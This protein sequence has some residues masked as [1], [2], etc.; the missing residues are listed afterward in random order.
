LTSP[1]AFGLHS[2]EPFPTYA[3]VYRGLDKIAIRDLAYCF[4]GHF[5][6]ENRIGARI[7]RLSAAIRHW[8]A[9]YS[10]S[11][12]LSLEAGDDLL[13][14][15]SRPVA[16]QFVTVLKG[17]WRTL[18]ARCERA[19]PKDA[20]LECLVR[21]LPTAEAAQEQ[22]DQFLATLLGDRLILEESGN[23]LSLAVPVDDVEQVPPRLMRHVKAHLSDC[24][25]SSDPG[26]SGCLT[27]VE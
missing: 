1:E 14:F 19:W 23:Y 27:H 25:T 21:M 6:G 18:Y 11:D 10:E 17:P 16:R 20:L 12:L 8:H 24:H 4:T 2:I 15:D 5:A 9:A 7:H 3:T 26:D 13:V 22:L